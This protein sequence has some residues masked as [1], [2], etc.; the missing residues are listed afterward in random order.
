[1]KK[2]AVLTISLLT[3]VLTLAGSVAFADEDHGITFYP[4]SFTKKLE[5]S[6]LTDYAI[7]DTS[8]GFAEGG[9]IKIVENETLASYSFDFKVTALDYADGVYYY[10]DG[11]GNGFSLPDNESAN[12]SFDVPAEFSLDNYNYYINDFG[13]NIIDKNKPSNEQEPPLADY[14]NLKQYGNNVY[15]VCGNTVYVLNGT[16]TK[17][18]TIDYIDYSDAKEIFIGGTLS[19]L[20]NLDINSVKVA[21]IRDFTADGSPVYITEIDLDGLSDT[22]FRTKETYCIGEKNAP[23]AGTNAL[24][25]CESGNSYIVAIGSIT[26]IMAKSGADVH[27]EAVLSPSYNSATLSVGG[28]AYT[29]YLPFINANTQSYSLTTGKN[30]TVIGMADKSSFPYLSYN[31]YIISYT[32]G[33]ETVIGYVPEGYLSEFT[34]I[35]KEPQTTVDPEYSED[36]LVKTVVLI[37]IVIALVLIALGYL[38]YVGTS[39]KKKKTKP[40][41]AELPNDSDANDK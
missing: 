7:G 6:A 27:A 16:Q 21:T 14:S 28:S 32:E 5:F 1:M 22:Y 35:D 13:L 15:A 24:L 34:F 10:K 36:D 39:D 17:A 18:I 25:L 9:T 41:P 4:E 38:I 11:N 2:L 29:Y 26:Y 37:L 12:H 19:A 30:V 8:Y 40:D 31:F 33:E 20:N 23:A 3:A